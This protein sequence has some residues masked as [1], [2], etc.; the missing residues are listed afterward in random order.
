MKSA[1]AL[2]LLFYLTAALGLRILLAPLLGSENLVIKSLA[3][4]IILAIGAFFVLKGAA[5]IIEQTTEVL[6]KRTNLA[7]GVLQA[8]GTAFP[9]MVLGVIAAFISLS[10]RQ[11]DYSR[12]VTYAI[13]AASTTFGSNIYNII[14]AAWCVY[15]QNRANKHNHAI[16]MIPRWK[17]T[18]M[19]LPINQ[20]AVP[21]LIRELDTANDILVALTV[22][23]AATAMS[24]VLFGKI[25]GSV[26]GVT[27]D[28]YQ[29]IQPAGLIVVLLSVLTV[30][31]FRKTKRK[32]SSEAESGVSGFTRMPSW[33]IFI[34]LSVSGIAILFAAE[35]MVRAVE[36]LSEMTGIPY[37]ISG[38][39][40]G[41]IGCLGEMIVIHN[42][43]IH[44]KGRIGDALVGVGMDNIVTTMGAGIVALMGGIFLGGSSL[45]VIFVIILASNTILLWQISKLKNV[46]I[47]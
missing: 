33:L 25:S 22:L 3:I 17:S 29:L 14:H 31:R 37:A 40:T 35:S 43:T 24:M 15:R 28:V 7:G 20:H 30:Y 23:T 32:E 10:L 6:S 39:L 18:G 41:L 36:A 26:A 8:L 16:S 19:V 46:L 12:A 13:L 45:I 11:S 47:Q 9:D 1:T 42:Y 21:P 2:P 5:E 27:E 4:F 44:P 34:Y 38:A